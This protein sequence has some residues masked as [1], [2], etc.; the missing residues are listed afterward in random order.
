LQLKTRRIALAGMLCALTEVI[1]LLGGVIPVAV[2]ACPILAMVVL[3]P[4]RE[5]CGT[6]LSLCAYGA[7]ALLALLLVPD[8]ELA[9]VYLFF[10]WY[11]AAQPALDR[12]GSRVVRF[13]AKLGIFVC[14]TAVL[15]AL[16][17]FVFQLSAVVGEYVES[18]RWILLSLL[19]LG[20]GVFFITDLLLRRMALL[21]RVKLRRRWFQS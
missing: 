7:T 6:K 21:W 5:E 3:L 14:A 10:G 8:K 15:Y 11:P 4:V 1:L 2:Y 20:C 18:S 19:V 13:I 17:I 9:G 12:I 16:L